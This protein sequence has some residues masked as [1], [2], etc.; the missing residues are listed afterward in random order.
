MPCVRLRPCMS[1]FDPLRTFADPATCRQM[2]DDEPPT[3]SLE[4]HLREGREAVAAIERQPQAHAPQ[5]LC[6]HFSG[7]EP[8][9]SMT[10]SI[11]D[12]YAPLRPAFEVLG[13]SFLSDRLE[14]WQNC[15]PNLEWLELLIPALVR[16]ASAHGLIYEGWSWEPRGRE[17]LGASTFPVMN[18]R[19]DA[20]VPD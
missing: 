4:D 19:S 12:T 17:P 1:A 7:V 3:W 16:T 14:A 11:E 15:Q 9:D 13:L 18:N 6:H 8:V 5:P 10:V 20:R 2:W